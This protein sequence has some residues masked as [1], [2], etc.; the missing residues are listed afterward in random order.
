MSWSVEGRVELVNCSHRFAVFARENGDT[1]AR[2]LG[3]PVFPGS[4]N[5][6]TS[7]RNIGDS[8]DL[9]F[10]PGEPDIV[11]P[12][13]EFRGMPSWL[14]DGRAW[15][16]VLRAAQAAPARCLLFRRKGSRVR[17]GIIE[18]LAPVGL[19]E[20]LGLKH[21]QAVSVEGET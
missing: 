11:I 7:R 8:L 20:S 6:R 1:L 9:G 13:A 14:G 2:H 3:G 17:T 5:I 18:L 16:C 4:L 10:W 15:R 21:G 12:K 19:V